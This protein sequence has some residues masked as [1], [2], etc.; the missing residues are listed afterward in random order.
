MV[1]DDGYMV[2]MTGNDDKNYCYWGSGID[3][4]VKCGYRV[5]KNRW[6]HLAIVK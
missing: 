3:C 1:N 5:A 4:A 6:T 2:F